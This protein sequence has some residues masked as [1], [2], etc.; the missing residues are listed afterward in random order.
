KLEFLEKTNRYGRL[1]TS[2]TSSNDKNN[3]LAA[4]FEITFA[5]QFESAG[6]A[7]DYEVKQADA[8][9]SSI[10]FLLRMPSGKSVFFEARLLQ[11][12][13]STTKS[14]KEQLEDSSFYQVAMNGQ[15]EHDAIV[16]L[17]NVILSKVQKPDGTP[18][19]FLYVAANVVNIVVVDVSDLILGTIDVHDCL[20]ATHG[21]PA[22]A[23][24]YRR[25]IFG[26]FQDPDPRYPAQIQKI[27]QSFEHIRNTLSGVL[28][29]FKSSKAS[30]LDYNLQQYMMW[31]SRLVDDGLAK[32]LLL[33]ISRA[34]PTR[35]SRGNGQ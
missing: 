15:D 24:V 21:D 19:K 25:G 16:R 22:V 1:L 30:A 12:D 8:D 18:T 5:F 20:L 3:F 28:F 13:A 35:G 6:F 17:Q 9:G 27:A 7:L 32:D 23:G 33:E 29:S 4:I 26:L 11:Q 14:I 31:N 10:D 2:I 34:L